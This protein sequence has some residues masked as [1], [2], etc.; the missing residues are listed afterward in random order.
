MSLLFE[1]RAWDYIVKQTQTQWVAKTS[2]GKTLATA[3]ANTSLE[4]LVNACL[5]DKGSSWGVVQLSPKGDA[6]NIDGAIDA[7]SN[8]VIRGTGPMQWSE[9]NLETNA[10]VNMLQPVGGVG[11]DDIGDVVLIDVAFDGNK[12]SQGGAGPYSCI[13]WTLGNA[14]KGSWAML[15]L[16]RVRA[17][18]AKGHCIDISTTTGGLATVRA[19]D[20]RAFSP[21][22]TFFG[23]HTNR[24]FDSWFDFMLL[25]N[26]QCENGFTSNHVGK[27]YLSGGDTNVPN[28]H[29]TN[30]NNEETTWAQIRSDWCNRDA[31]DIDNAD[32]NNF[33]IIQVTQQKTFDDTYAAVLLEGNAS[34]NIID[35]VIVGFRASRSA[36][37]WKYGVEINDTASDNLIN[38]VNCA[39]GVV[40]AEVFDIPANGNTFGKIVRSGGLIGRYVT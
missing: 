31:I 28:L 29:L 34:D 9:F 32:H 11:D 15:S 2:F 14:D 8:T 5:V 12:G 24:I 38:T 6:M 22:Q 19:I 10:N 16:Y 33:G 25:Q 20:V 13:D 39:D 35:N 23:L 36:H 18:D 7:P 26:M 4:D 30:S 21:Q 3:A 27:L 37:K 17:Q 1:D 40:T